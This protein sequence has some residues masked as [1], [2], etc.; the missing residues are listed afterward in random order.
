M[1]HS[2]SYFRVY[3]FFLFFIR[4]LFVF[5]L[6]FQQNPSNTLEITYQNCSCPFQF[7]FIFLIWPLISSPRTSFTNSFILCSLY[8]NIPICYWPDSSMLSFNPWHSLK[9]ALIL[10]NCSDV[11]DWKDSRY[12][13]ISTRIFFVSSGDLLGKRDFDST[14]LSK[15]NCK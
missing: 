10:S 14:I 12:L 9:T 1:D 8:L 7:S 2:Y 5:T 11:F 13:S 3:T 4:T 15:A 6:N